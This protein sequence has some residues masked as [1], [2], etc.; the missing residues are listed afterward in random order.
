MELIFHN[1]FTYTAPLNSVR[2]DPLV[3][4]TVQYPGVIP[5]DKFIL[6]VIRPELTTLTLVAVIV[7]PATNGLYMLTPQPPGN[8]APL[9]DMLTVPVLNTSLRDTPV[10]PN[11]VTFTALYNV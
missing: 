10:T 3:T 1:R 9:T 11:P 8:P 2:Y 4:A 6:N 7:L 5:E